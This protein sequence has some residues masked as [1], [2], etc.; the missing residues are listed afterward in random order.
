MN[1]IVDTIVLVLFVLI[2]IF[3]VVGFNRQTVQNYH[4]KIEARD[5]RHEEALNK[6]NNIEEE[7]TDK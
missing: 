4:D 3:F 5:R 2:L 7:E 1:P 6:Q